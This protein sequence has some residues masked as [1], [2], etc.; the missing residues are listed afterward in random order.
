MLKEFLNESKGFYE[1]DYATDQPEKY[2]CLSCLSEVKKE[3]KEEMKDDGYT[4][5]EIASELAGRFYVVGQV[6]QPTYCNECG[7]YIGT[8][9]V[10]GRIDLLKKASDN[11]EI[12]I[13]KS[14]YA[15]NACYC[16]FGD[17]TD[18]NS[19]LEIFDEYGLTAKAA[20]LAKQLCEKY[21]KE[22]PELNLVNGED[23]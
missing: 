20:K 10:Q 3:L 1:K 12:E 5:E 16:N 13:E 8:L 17:N 15:E 21:I 4:K 22:H 23:L 2:F 14:D 18:G 19:F 6:D 11:A 7:Q 9:S